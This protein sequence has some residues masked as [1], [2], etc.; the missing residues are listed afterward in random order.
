MTRGTVR[1]AIVAALACAMLA[2]CN[3]I[4][5]IGEDITGVATWTQGNMPTSGGY[6]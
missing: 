2:G 3:T 6:Y 1:L 4:A 5:G